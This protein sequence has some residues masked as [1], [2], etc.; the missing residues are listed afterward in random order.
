MADERDAA[1][2]ISTNA[3]P[4]LKQRLLGA[5]NQIGSSILI[6]DGGVSTHLEHKLLDGEPFEFRQLWSSSL[7]LNDRGRR[8]IQQGHYDW[9][10]AGADIM[11]TVTYQCH[12]NQ[13]LWPRGSSGTIVLSNEQVNQMFVDGVTLARQAQ[14]Q[15]NQEGNRPTYVVA[16]LGCYGAA[17]ANGA[18]YTGDYERQS[19]DALVEFHRN[20]FDQALR[21]QPDAIAFETIPSYTECLALTQLLNNVSLN[22]SC[23]C[24]ISLACRNGTELNDGTP[25]LKA[26][27]VLS[28]LPSDTLQ[29]IGFNC[30]D[31]QYIPLLA[32]TLATHMAQSSVVTRAI[33]LYPNTGELW[34]AEQLS[35][36][37]GTG[38]VDTKDFANH[39]MTAIASIE[40][41]WPRASG[42]FPTIVVGGCCRTEPEAIVELR[43]RVD[44]HDHDLKQRTRSAGI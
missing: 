33:L 8:L 44:D 29:G 12:Y 21:C 43:R 18:E 5:S 13:D 31:C 25:L 9:I 11:T 19:Q 22:S 10:H 14:Q 32:T 36:K 2:E 28:A 39:L 24:W 16:S 3:A 20:K 42:P 30:C 26:L 7:L 15:V 17:L 41:S 38:C 1:I 23:A 4:T 40:D 34:N 27:D 6:L 35:W 37:Q